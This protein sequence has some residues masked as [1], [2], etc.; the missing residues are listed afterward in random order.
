MKQFGQS[1]TYW[2][3]KFESIEGWLVSRK[4][5][6]VS[7]VWD[8]GLTRGRKI[9]EVANEFP[10]LFKVGSQNPNTLCTGLWTLGRF[11]GARI[12]LAPDF[13]LD[14]LPS[15]LCAHGEIW[16]DDNLQLITSICKKSMEK[17]KEVENLWLAV[18][19]MCFA[20]PTYSSLGLPFPYMKTTV[21]TKVGEAFRVVKKT[22]VNSKAQLGEWLQTYKS[23]G[24]EG[25]VFERPNAEYVCDRTKDVLKHKPDYE[26][27]AV[28][29]GYHDG[30][31]SN[32]G[33]M[34]SLIVVMK[35]SEKHSGVAGFLGSHVGKIVT[36]KMSGFLQYM[37]E[38][39]YVKANFPTGTKVNFTYKMLSVHGVPQSPNFKFVVKE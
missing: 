25:L 36:F 37:R 22:A 6:G 14:G 1:L 2:D 21:H 11:D 28:V 13:F 34:G 27:E 7:A 18:K 30:N 32:L 23:E 24:W 4:Y 19:F 5:N 29:I 12:I 9:S 39:D 38:W 10:H 31:K 35:I 8:G 3:G 16:C 33:K 20:F 17:I 26:D 15:G